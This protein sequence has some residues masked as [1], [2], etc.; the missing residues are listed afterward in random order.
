M[1]N[2]FDEMME[3]FED[4][5][6]DDATKFNVGA[7]SSFIVGNKYKITFDK[8]NMKVKISGEF[9]TLTYYDLKYIYGDLT[10]Y[11]YVELIDNSFTFV[12]DDYYY[13][14]DFKFYLTKNGEFSVGGATITSLGAMF[15]LNESGDYCGFTSGVLTPGN[16]YTISLQVFDEN[17][18]YVMV[19][20]K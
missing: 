11:S 6:Y 19:T 3:Y 1:D 20:E 13:Y 17:K 9:K 12:A 7:L 10:D 18:A 14:D 5:I 8:A 4:D 16:E 2:Q 15:P